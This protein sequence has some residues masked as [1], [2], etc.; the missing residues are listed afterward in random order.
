[1]EALVRSRLLMNRGRK[2]WC[3]KVKFRGGRGCQG[4][5]RAKKVKSGEQWDGCRRRMGLLHS[6]YPKGFWWWNGS[7]FALVIPR[8]GMGLTIEDPIKPNG[9]DSC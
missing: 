4:E 5:K 2:D 6:L 9:V 7:F 1:M 8:D 3:K